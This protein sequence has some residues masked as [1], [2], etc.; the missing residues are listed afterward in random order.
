MSRIA[1]TQKTSDVNIRI[2]P[3]LKAEAERV[4]GYHGLTLPE[5]VTVFIKHACRVG[6][7]PFDLRGAPYTDLESMEALNE[8]YSLMNDPNAKKFNNVK[9]LFEECLKDNND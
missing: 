6:G 4:F 5:A 1:H 7:F 2:L 9:S 3:E 8:A